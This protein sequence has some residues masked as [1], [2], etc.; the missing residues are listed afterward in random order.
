[1]KKL[2]NLK[3]LVN[4]KPESAAKERVVNG[5]IMLSNVVN[6]L[7]LAEGTV[8]AVGNGTPD[9]PMEVKVGD[10]IMFRNG[11]NR[12]NIDGNVLLDQDDVLFIL[13]PE[14]DA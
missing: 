10:L 12:L 3:L 11:E 1:M 9:I 8:V 5:I 7:M 13:D 6:K 14:Q 4:P 2:G